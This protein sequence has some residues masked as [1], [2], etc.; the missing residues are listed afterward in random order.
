MR[1]VEPGGDSRREGALARPARSVYGDEHRACLAK[2]Q[3]ADVI[4]DAAKAL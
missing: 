4:D 2:P 1:S 3:V